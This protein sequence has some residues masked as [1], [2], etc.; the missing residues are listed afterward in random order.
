MKKTLLSSALGLLVGFAFAG[1]DEEEPEPGTK[2]D[3]EA[4]IMA[5]HTKDDGTDE[6][7]NG[8]CHQPAHD[9]AD[10]AAGASFATC[11]ERKDEC[12]ELCN[13]APEVEMDSDHG[14]DHDS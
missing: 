4:I 8:Y 3:C 12:V 5:C 7:I 14:D 10:G 11:A 1:C 9:A 2:A 13:E 6:M